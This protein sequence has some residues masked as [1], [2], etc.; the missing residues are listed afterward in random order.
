MPRGNRFEAKAAQDGLPRSVWETYSA[1]ANTSGGV[2]ALGVEELPDGR[3]RAIGVPDPHDMIEDFWNTA[4]NPQ[5]VNACVVADGDVTVSDEG[6]VLIR[7]PRADRRLKP[8]YLNDNPKRSFRRNHAGD[9]LCRY[10]EVQSMMR[11]AAETSRDSLKT[12]FRLDGIQRVDDTP[13]HRALREALAN[14]LANANYHERRGVV[15]VWEPDAIRI[16][17]PGDFRVDI[18]DALRGG[19]S[20]PRN[21]GMLKIFSYVD[22]GERAGSGVPT[23]VGGWE[24]SG[25]AAPSWLEEFGPDRTT[26]TLPLTGAGEG[27]SADSA[28]VVESGGRMVETGG[29]NG[30]ESAKRALLELARGE[31]SVTRREAVEVTGYDRTW[32]SRL[33]KELVSEGRL[34]ATGT[35]R[36]RAYRPVRRDERPA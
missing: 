32:T 8:V 28:T 4:N 9:Y 15:C 33:L 2:I 20:D 1:F 36:D 10:D 27:V 7:V 3:L 13:A 21:E 22:V 16:S 26:L 35:T 19:R 17:N 14:C 30:K 11:D 6:V 29:Q 12:P 18:E 25:Y 31:G 5:K 24:E 23:I 34:E